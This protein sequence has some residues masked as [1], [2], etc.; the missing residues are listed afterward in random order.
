MWSVLVAL[1]LLWL[2]W[3]IF[4]YCSPTLM[5]DLQAPLNLALLRAPAQSYSDQVVNLWVEKSWR[6]DGKRIPCRIERY[7]PNQ[8]A[9]MIILY[10]HSNGE[11]LLS[12]IQFMREACSA[13]HCDMLAWD[14]SGYGLNEADKDERDAEGINMSLRAVAHTLQETYGY[15]N[16]QMVLWGYSLGT[17][18]TLAVA[19]DFPAL[20][21]VVCVAAFTSVQQVV[22]DWTHPNI[23]QWITERWDNVRAIRSLECPILLIHGQ[24]D[25]L[26]KVKHAEELKRASPQAQLVIL[27]QTGH[28]LINWSDLFVHVQKW[29]A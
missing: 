25:T 12:C 24:N 16:D 11:N 18:P 8:N 9:A 19:N 14:Y 17:G 23:S 27:P 26:V 3:S 22:E 2:V 15:S 21:G 1:L 7:K 29:L 5:M 20:K 13:L 10:S 4:V 28:T 6:H